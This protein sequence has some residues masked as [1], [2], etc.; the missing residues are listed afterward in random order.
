MKTIIVMRHAKADSKSPTDNDYDRKLKKK[1]VIAAGNV[2]KK[3]S[4]IKTIPDLIISSPVVRAV[5]TAEIMAQILDLQQNIILRNYLYNRLY[6]FK[7]IVEDIFMNNAEAKTVIVIGHNPGVSYL[8]NQINSKCNDILPT[9][10][11]VVFDFEVSNWNEVTPEKSIRRC[12]I[13]KDKL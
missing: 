5:S 9:S 12:T 1:G 7:E 13:D 2:A 10:C 11:A 4:E 3:I 6:T 8:L